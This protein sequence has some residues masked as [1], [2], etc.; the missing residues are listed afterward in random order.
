M[1]EGIHSNKMCICCELSTSRDMSGNSCS[2]SFH[3][4][5]TI[6]DAYDSDPIME[7]PRTKLHRHP[8]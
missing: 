1:N 3:G 7:I 6:I 4:H 8:H 2:S 5:L